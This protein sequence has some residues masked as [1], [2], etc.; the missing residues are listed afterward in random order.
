[1]DEIWALPKGMMPK[2]NIAIARAKTVFIGADRGQKHLHDC[3]PLL[4]GK[5]SMWV[6]IG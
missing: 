3:Q 5:K 4:K 6:D 1:L 2:R